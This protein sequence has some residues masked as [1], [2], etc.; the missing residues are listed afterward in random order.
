[1]V[2]V[3]HSMLRDC[4]CKYSPFILPL[5]IIIGVEVDE[6]LEFTT[7]LANGKF[8]SIEMDV[9]IDGGTN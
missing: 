7:S 5:F 8:K 2:D 6:R 3:I 9:G 1:M 4:Y